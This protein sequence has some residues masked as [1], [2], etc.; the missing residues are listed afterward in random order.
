[1]SKEDCGDAGPVTSCSSVR[2]TTPV[3]CHCTRG[4]RD[5]TL[6]CLQSCTSVRLMSREITVLAWTSHN[7]ANAECR[8]VIDSDS[9]E[10]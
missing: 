6:F 5:L 10:W 2:P 7:I 1:M 9:G 8:P 4:R 3:D